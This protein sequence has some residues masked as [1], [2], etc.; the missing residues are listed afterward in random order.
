MADQVRVHCLARGPGI[1]I[2]WLF[3]AE[4]AHFTMSMRRLG[5]ADDFR[6][7]LLPNLQAFEI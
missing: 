6:E 7:L 2:Q 5:K 3:N 1:C 4:L